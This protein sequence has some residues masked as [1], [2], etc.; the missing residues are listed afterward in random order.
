M[1]ITCCGITAALSKRVNWHWKDGF[2]EEYCLVEESV[3][4]ERGK[5]VM[6]IS[7]QAQTR[8]EARR[9]GWGRTEESGEEC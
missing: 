3:F 4:S 6:D 1:K 5:G 9:V 8:E 2:G 7:R